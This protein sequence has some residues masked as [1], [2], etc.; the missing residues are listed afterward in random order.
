MP[1]VTGGSSGTTSAASAQQTAGPYIEN[2]ATATLPQS[3]DGTLFTIAG[4]NIVLLS[5]VGEVT[6]L[7]QSL[8]NNMKIKFNPT[9]TGADVDLCSTEDVTADAVG[10]FYSITGDLLDPLQVG[11]YYV[12][13]MA[14]PLVL[15]PGLIELDCDA[16]STGSVE[17]HLRWSPID[18]SATV[19]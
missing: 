3:A 19:S 15:G 2:L 9:G 12:E 13:F 16:S 7:I 6:T 10:S 17:W 1:I 4:G 5:L 11:L 14:T 18:T 8:A